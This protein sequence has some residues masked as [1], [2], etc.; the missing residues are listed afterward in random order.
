MADYATGACVEIATGGVGE[1]G[2]S[3]FLLHRH[4]EGGGGG[5]GE[6]VAVLRNAE[7]SLCPN[8]G[9]VAML[10]VNGQPVAQGDITAPGSAISANVTDGDVVAAIVHTVPLFND[11]SCVRLG[12]LSVV[13]EE[14][15]L[16]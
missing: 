16:V 2:E 6:K 9:A 3:S 1:S 15:D 8:T 7:T 5:G 4:D 12:E 10:V 14:C 11:I 13:L